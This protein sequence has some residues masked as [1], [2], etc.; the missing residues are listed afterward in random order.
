MI[1]RETLFM[2]CHTLFSGLDGL[3]GLGRWLFF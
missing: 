2:N 3:Q 1:G